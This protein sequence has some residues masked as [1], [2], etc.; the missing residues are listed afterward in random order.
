MK[1]LIIIF[2]L[3]T[4]NIFAQEYPKYLVTGKDTI[5]IVI[6]IKQAQLIDRDLD[7]LD[8]FKK[9]KISSEMTESTYIKVI[10]DMNKGV[11]LYHVKISELE[12]VNKIQTSMIDDLNKQ[13]FNYK[14][15]MSLCDVQ[16]SKK[17]TIINNMH[18]TIKK[19]KFQKFVG[20][21]F[22]VVS[23]ATLVWVVLFRH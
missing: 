4:S 23:F 2:M 3:F 20:Y 10:D 22:G 16:S 14:L 17:D 8:L 7:I 11:V 18:G 19:L 6:T 9:F 1:K 5:G 21:T 15:D 12:K 13:I